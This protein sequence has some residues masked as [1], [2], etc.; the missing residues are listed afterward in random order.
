MNATC[1][2]QFLD[3]ICTR[4]VQCNRCAEASCKREFFFGDINGSDDRAQPPP[5]LHGQVTEAADAENRQTLASL[6]FGVLQGTIDRDPRA[7]KRCR[8]DAGK[9]VRNLQGMT[10]GSLHEFCVA[11]IYGYS[12][13]L[14]LDAK[15]L[16]A[17]AAEF[18]FAARP[19][20]PRDANAIANFQVTDGGAFFHNSA[21]DFVSKDQGRLGNGNDFRPVAVGH[22]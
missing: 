1:A 19:V 13:N 14:L 2:P 3:N 15:I 7:E 6:D 12:S 21:S 11:A 17:F 10:R 16:I 5:D 20:Y 22:V 8:V 18:A 4:R 9:S